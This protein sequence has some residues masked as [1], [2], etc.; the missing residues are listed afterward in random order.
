M[1]LTL[2]FSARL[3]IQMPTVSALDLTCQMAAQA[4]QE[5]H[6]GQAHQEANF[7]AHQEASFQAFQKADC[8]AGC[9]ANELA[10]AQADELAHA[11]ADEAFYRQAN[12]CSDLSFLRHMYWTT[13]L[14]MR[15]RSV[16]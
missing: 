11:Q 3:S 16:R 10:H 7:Q 9:K 13:G 12:N 4:H 6:E 5:G 1:A 14:A 2:P 15:V 8:Q